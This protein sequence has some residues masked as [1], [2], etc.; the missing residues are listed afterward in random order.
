MR[1]FWQS[2]TIGYLVVAC[3]LFGM[4]SFNANPYLWIASLLFTAG[5]IFC[6]VK[7]LRDPHGGIKEIFDS[8]K[9][10]PIVR[11]LGDG[12]DPI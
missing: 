5:T 8:G 11:K 3:L 2:Q 10:V 7:W 4:I 6:L 9:G 1:F 12:H